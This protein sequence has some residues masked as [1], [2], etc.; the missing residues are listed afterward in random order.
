VAT[1]GWPAN[2]P[3]EN[4]PTCSSTRSQSGSAWAV[5]LLR[6]ARD[7]ARCLGYE[8]LTID[9]DPYA[10]AFYVHGGAVRS[11]ETPSGSIPGRM[12]PR[13]ELAVGTGS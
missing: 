7:H 10:E 2:R 11:G 1:T 9:A 5:P 13:L 8:L 3:A 12:L 6:D 4:S